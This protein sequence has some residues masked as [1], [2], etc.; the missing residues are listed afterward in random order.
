MQK[1]KDISAKKD[2]FTTITILESISDAI[3]ILDK[4]GKIKYANKGALNILRI[5]IDDL[6]GRFIDEIL[7]DDFD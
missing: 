5:D 4:D 7:I 3:F 1:R 2:Y 6:I